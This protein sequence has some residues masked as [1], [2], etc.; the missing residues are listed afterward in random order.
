MKKGRALPSHGDCVYVVYIDG[1]VHYAGRTNCLYARMISH[2][3]ERGFSFS[4]PRV[5]VKASLSRRYGEHAMRELRLIAKLSPAGN[6]NHLVGRSGPW[7]GKPWLTAA[8][9]AAA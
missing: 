5:T 3:K 9:K 2:A 8:W 1:R 4:D 6:K 7:A